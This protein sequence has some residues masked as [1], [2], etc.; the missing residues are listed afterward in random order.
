MPLT[1][2]ARYILVWFFAFCVAALIYNIS[3]QTG[4]ETAGLSYPS[5]EFF[6]GLIWGAPTAAQIEAMHYLLRQAF[7]VALFF[8]FGCSFCLAGV[9]TFRRT[10]LCI[11]LPAVTVLCGAAAYFDEWRKQFIPGRHYEPEQGIINVICVAAGAAVIGLVTVFF[12]KRKG[13]RTEQQ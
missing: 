12:R 6:A 10:R 8:A 5:A 13:K 9:I 7:R 4:G 11:L 1:K 2:K 3:S